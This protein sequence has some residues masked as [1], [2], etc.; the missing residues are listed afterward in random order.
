MKN[1]VEQHTLCIIKPDAMRNQHQ[2]LVLQRIVDEGFS[3]C[4]LR[5]LRLSAGA[6]EALYAVHR[7]RPFFA[8]LVVRMTTGSVI[9]AA[10]S[11]RDAV[12]H[13]RAVIG[14]TDPAKAAAGTLRQLIGES[15][16][17]NSVHG[18]DSVENGL[19]ETAFF[20][21]GVELGR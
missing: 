1:G 17:N 5:M 12:V 11:R 18:S 20:F 10:L 4:A 6:A 13:W 14:N 16:S 7:E 8:D 15:L 2:G 9:V 21:T 3:L 19:R